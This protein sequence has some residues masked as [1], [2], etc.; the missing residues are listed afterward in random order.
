MS[1]KLMNLNGTKSTGRTEDKSIDNESQNKSQKNTQTF[2]SQ[3][4]DNRARSPSDPLIARGASAVGGSKLS[5]MENARLDI[6]T[7]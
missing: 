7:T 4:S 6:D 5:Y 1:S 2:V 3:S